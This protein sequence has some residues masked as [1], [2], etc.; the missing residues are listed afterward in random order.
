MCLGW[1]VIKTDWCV[2]WGVN[3]TDCFTGCGVS[4]LIEVNK[5]DRCKAVGVNRTDMG[6]Y[7]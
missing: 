3:I 6:L 2:D 7:C 1:G 5:N 4:K